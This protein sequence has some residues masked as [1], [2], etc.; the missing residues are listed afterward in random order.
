MNLRPTYCVRRAVRP[1]PQRIDSSTSAQSHAQCHLSRQFFSSRANTAFALPSRLLSL[2][3]LLAVG[4]GLAAL[5]PS[6]HGQPSVTLAWDPSASSGIAAYR[7]YEGGASRT[8]TNVIAAGN[9]TTATAPNLLSGATYYFAV[10]AVDST[11]LESAYSNEIIYTVPLPT[12]LPPTVALRVP[13]NGAVYTAPATIG[14][15]AGVT[16]N[17]HTISQVQF[18]NGSTLLGTDTVALYTLSWTNV[19]AGTYSLSAKVIYDSGSSAAS[20]AV[21]VI[22]A[23]ARPAPSLTFAADS[24][25]YT[26][27]FV[28]NN[29]TLSQPAGPALTGGGRAAYTFNITSAGKYLVSADVIAPSDAENSLYVNIDAEPTD[30]LMIWDIPISSTLTNQTV[31]WRGNGTSN[32]AT[33]QYNPAAFYLSVGQHQLII[34]GREANT[35]F[36]TITIAPKRPSLSINTLSSTTGNVAITVPLSPTPLVI[37][38]DGIAGQTYTIASSSNLVTWTVIGAVTLDA[39]GSGQFSDPAGTSRPRC[40]YMIQGP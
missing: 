2:A 12:N 13:T 31:S 32:P 27:P 15:V 26:A 24:G 8:Y 40:F 5:T 6:L 17:G 3:S 34:R 10:T 21:N 33:A 28:A 22:V 7:L 29:G 19:S 30:P 9:A 14:L 18:Y 36:G 11:G 20:P 38:V 37:N 35:T 16:A 1:P 25:T 4:L 39:T 23:A